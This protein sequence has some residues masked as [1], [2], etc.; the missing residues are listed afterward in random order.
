MFFSLAFSRIWAFFYVLYVGI[1]ISCSFSCLFGM[2]FFT[3]ILTFKSE[4]KKGVIAVLSRSAEYG[5]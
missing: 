3:E 1:I 5:N 4:R 2:S